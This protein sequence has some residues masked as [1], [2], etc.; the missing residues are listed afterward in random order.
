M[1]DLH[2]HLDPSLEP[3]EHDEYILDTPLIR[4]FVDAVK[5]AIAHAAAP[6]DAVAAIEPSFLKL[7]QHQDWLPEQY[8]HDAPDSGMGGGIGQWLLFRSADRS[9]CLFSLVVPPGSRTP[10]HDHLAW[11]LI[12][13][14]RGNQDEEFYRPGSGQLELIRRRPLEPGDWYPLLPPRDDIHCVR[15]T[16]PMTSVS[17]H[18]LAN[19][20]GCVLRHVYDEETGAPT[21]FRSGYVNASCPEGDPISSSQ[22]CD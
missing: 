3:L 21:P 18:L 15:T 22:D 10:V 13:L 1:C 16:S 4:G 17:I 14:Y 19:D 7:L 9:L 20:T 5:G 11:G 2:D 12:G 8:Q 6:R